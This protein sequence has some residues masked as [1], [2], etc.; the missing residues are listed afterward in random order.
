MFTK[1]NILLQ[2]LNIFKN[3]KGVT[4]IEKD[5]QERGTIIIYVPLALCNVTNEVTFT[6][7]VSEEA[8]TEP[9]EEF[10]NFL[11]INAGIGLDVNGKLYSFD[12]R[13]NSNL[14]VGEKEGKYQTYTITSDVTITE[15]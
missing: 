11:K 10:L 12:F 9:V 3:F 1:N 5:T 7:K 15:E 14:I 13:N 4:F 6:I 8:K 2:Y